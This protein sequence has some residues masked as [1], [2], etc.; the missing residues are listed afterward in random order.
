MLKKK[1]GGS[2]SSSMS[3][4]VSVDL[5]LSFWRLLSSPLVDIWMEWLVP[6]VHYVWFLLHYHFPHLGRWCPKFSWPCPSL[7]PNRCSFIVPFWGGEW[8]SMVIMGWRSGMGYSLLGKRSNLWSRHLIF[9]EFYASSYDH[10]ICN[11][12]NKVTTSWLFGA[13]QVA[14][15]P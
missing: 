10:D 9:W 1:I 3:M 13:R 4:L 6:I 12:E 7:L 14:L 15:D 5:S 8:G 2:V 11:G